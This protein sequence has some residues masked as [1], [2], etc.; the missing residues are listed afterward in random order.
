MDFGLKLKLNGKKLCPKNSVKYLG[1]KIDEQWTWKPHIHG[2]SAKLCKANAM[3]S[4]IRHFV[5]QKTLKAIYHAIFESHLHYS[6]LVRAQ[7][8]NSKGTLF[9]LQKKALGLMSFLRREAHA[10]PLFKDFNFL[11]LHD[12]TALENSIFMHKSFKH[13]LPQLFDNWFG[14]S[15]NFYTHNAMWSNLDSHLPKNIFFYFFQW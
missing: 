1:I 3:L 7:N 10:N 2:I 9:T 13:Q 15:P 5:D 14:L 4:K 11:K 8:F 12:K 6:Y